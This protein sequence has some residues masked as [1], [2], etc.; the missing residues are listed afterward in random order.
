[1]SKKK[2]SLTDVCFAIYDI[3]KQTF[4]VIEQKT[5]DVVLRKIVENYD[6]R[7]GK[8]SKSK[9]TDV[10]Y[11]KL[12]KQFDSSNNLNNQLRE[13]IKIL[14]DR[15]ESISEDLKDASTIRDEVI[16][17]NEMFAQE[18]QVLRDTMA[19]F[20][21]T[22]VETLQRENKHPQKEITSSET[23]IGILF[24]EPDATGAILRKPSISETKYSLYKLD[25][26][27][28]ND[29]LCYFSVLNNNATETYIANRNVSLLACQILEIASNPTSF[30]T[31]EPG[32]AVKENNNWV[33]A[34]PAKIKIV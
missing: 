30:V 13:R 31:V 27:D 28:S 10:D 11:I 2:V 5:I 9:N 1:M 16:Q 29:Q 3:A 14:E 4:C 6:K 8:F 15:I 18:I 20:S 22:K 25:I 19:S 24:A 23:K 26:S 34:S 32:T 7:N 17:T 21:R 12:K 33:V